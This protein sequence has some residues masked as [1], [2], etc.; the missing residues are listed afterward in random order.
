MLTPALVAMRDLYMKS[1][2]GFLLVFSIC[3]KASFEELESIR[4]DIIRIKDDEDIPIVI[5][6]N[7]SDLEDMRAVDRAKAFA[8]S[9]RWNAPYYEASAR[10]RSRLPQPITHSLGLVSCPLCLSMCS[11]FFFFSADG[12]SALSSQRR[13][14]VSPSL[15]AD[16]P[17]G[18]QPGRAVQGRPHVPT[19]RRVFHQEA[20]AEEAEGEVRHLM[21]RSPSLLSRGC[22]RC[23]GERRVGGA[24]HMDDGPDMSYERRMI[25]GNALHD[26][27]ALGLRGVSCCRIDSRPLS[28]PRLIYMAFSFSFFFFIS[29]FSVLFLFL[30]VHGE[31]VVSV[32]EGKHTYSE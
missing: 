25:N 9:Q 17:A 2:H 3:S 10:T 16:A 1:G 4:D 29:F 27:N 28:S 30:F 13:R 7:K 21:T 15:P 6:G 23:S 14:G 18:G 24:G 31:P 22:G 20:T 32:F 8:L 11:F 26:G 5:V 12:G 19:R